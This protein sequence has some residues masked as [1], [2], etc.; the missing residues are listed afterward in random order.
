[1][2][3]LDFPAS[4][5]D[6]EVAQLRPREARIRGFLDRLLYTPESVNDWIEGRGTNYINERYEGQLGWVP[7]PGRYAHGVDGSVTTYGYDRSGARRMIQH[8]GEPCRINTYGN[9]FTHCDQVNDGETW[10]EALAAHLGEPVR[11]WGVSG[12]SVYQMYVRMKRQEQSHPGRLLIVNIY[13][14][15]HHRN[16]YAWSSLRLMTRHPDVIREG[17][18][19]PTMPFVEVDLAD[20]TITERENPCPTG[21]SLMRLSDPDW[22]YDSFKDHFPVRVVVARAALGRRSPETNH[23][24]IEQI[25]RDFGLTLPADSR[26]PAASLEALYVEAALFASMMIVDLMEELAGADGKH[27]LY[28]LSHT[29][30]HLGSAL[31]D[32][33]RTDRPFVD[34]LDERGLPYVDLMGVHREEFS[35]LDL[36]VPDYLRR[37]YNAHYN[38]LGNHFTAF[39]IKDLVVGL[40]E[41]KPPAYA[42]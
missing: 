34:F 28:V 40:L 38:P 41:P 7:A 22:V 23:A 3:Y 6:E 12:Q 4:D 26:D 36:S 8:R 17:I 39:A 33:S 16:L 31:S 32:G 5:M 2:Q 37:Y 35:R 18:H 9:S 25:A 29:E 10:Q 42:S 13:S 1:M 19:R 15:D 20:G 27:I 11:N 30:K 24:D 14:D 21:E